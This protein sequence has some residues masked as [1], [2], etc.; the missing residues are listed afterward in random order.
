M[1][2][3]LKYKDMKE[4]SI[5][6]LSSGG[7][8]IKGKTRKFF[9]KFGKY[10]FPIIVALVL[11]SHI[12]NS[13]MWNNYNKKYYLHF[14]NKF[15]VDESCMDQR[16]RIGYLVY[17]YHGYDFTLVFD[18]PQKNKYNFKVRL[19]SGGYSLAK[20]KPVYLETPLSEYRYE[21]GMSCFIDRFGNRK[22]DFSLWEYLDNPDWSY[23]TF[24]VVLKEDGTFVYDDKDSPE[25]TDEQRKIVEYFRKDIL[26]LKAEIDKI[27]S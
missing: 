14:V 13:I 3:G 6:A 4:T 19:R 24:G 15:N 20:L 17:K 12:I 22:Y 9:S 25:I 5:S 8:A 11:L 26:D 21:Y 16:L 1:K 23:D 27:L 18:E 10:I 2:D 7:G